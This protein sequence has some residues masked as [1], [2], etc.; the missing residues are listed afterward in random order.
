MIAKA[1]EILSRIFKQTGKT[2]RKIQEFLG[3]MF[4]RTWEYIVKV[5]GKIREILRETC[6][7]ERKTQIINHKS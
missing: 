1:W 7:F 3:N 5:E 6:F 4:E 2:F